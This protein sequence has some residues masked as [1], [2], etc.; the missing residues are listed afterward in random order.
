M[1]TKTIDVIKTRGEEE[2]KRQHPI[3][4]DTRYLS[5]ASTKYCQELPFQLKKIPCAKGFREVQAS[6][7]EIEIECGMRK[8]D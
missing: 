4:V 8:S 6:G 3:H 7:F 5:P 1:D 2:G